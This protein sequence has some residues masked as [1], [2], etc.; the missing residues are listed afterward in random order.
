MSAD[1][2][3]TVSQNCSA[4]GIGTI[5]IWHGDLITHSCIPPEIIRRANGCRAN[6]HSQQYQ[7]CPG[8]CKMSWWLSMCVRIARSG[9]CMMRRGYRKVINGRMWLA[10]RRNWASKRWALRCWAITVSR[11]VSKIPTERPGAWYVYPPDDLLRTVPLTVI[12]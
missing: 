9:D 7:L 5:L 6:I 2:G 8:N 4:V 12:N 1:C 3:Q 10:V 11:R